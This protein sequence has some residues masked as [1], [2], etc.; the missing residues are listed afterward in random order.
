MYIFLF[1]GKCEH[2]FIDLFCGLFLLHMVDSSAYCFELAIFFF[3]WTYK[4]SLCILD[5]NCLSVL[6]VE[7]MLFFFLYYLLPLPE[8]HCKVIKSIFAKTKLP[9]FKS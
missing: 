5:I 4:N 1:T 2:L 3:L 9:G 8:V 6:G 7:I